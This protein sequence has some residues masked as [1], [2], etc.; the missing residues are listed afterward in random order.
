MWS[1]TIAIDRNYLVVSNNNEL[2]VVD[3]LS[4]SNLILTIDSLA[5]VF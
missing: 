5:V 3:I 2:D 4:T 1:A